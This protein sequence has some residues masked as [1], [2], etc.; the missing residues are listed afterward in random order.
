MVPTVVIQAGQQL[1]RYGRAQ[2]NI[3]AYDVNQHSVFNGG[4]AAQI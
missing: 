2:C 1:L 4:A 3:K